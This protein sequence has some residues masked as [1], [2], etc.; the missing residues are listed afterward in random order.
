[1][2]KSIPNLAIVGIGRWGR[3]LI[4]EFKNLEKIGLCRLVLCVSSG[5]HENLDQLKKNHPTVVHTTDFKQALSDPTID[6][7]VIATPPRT[8]FQ[9]AS[10]ALK[11]GKHIFVEKPPAENLATTKRLINLAKQAK[12]ILFIDNI[13]IYHPLINKV[14]KL[15]KGRNLTSVEFVWL[16]EGTFDTDIISNL[17]YH[18]F[19]IASYLIGEPSSMR[20][21]EAVDGVTIC[22]RIKFTMNIE[23][24]EKC[25]VS[26]NRI[27]PIK[28]KQIT[29]KSAKRTWVW[30]D[31]TLYQVKPNEGLQEVARLT[32]EPLFLS[33]KEFIKCLTKETSNLESNMLALVAMRLS[34]SLKAKLNKSIA[35]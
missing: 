20:L 28:H 33:C 34:E 5:N 7:I 3:N 27:S 10:Q 30:T 1:M 4:K 26:I 31:K 2:K 19:I 9:L 32:A 6:A 35:A 16:K 24:I 22:D 12:R 25:L 15:I 11:A 18:D 21:E 13:Y 23:G 17:V 8:H 29:F 14:K